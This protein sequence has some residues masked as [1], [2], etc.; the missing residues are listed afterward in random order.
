MKDKRQSRVV[1]YMLI[2]A[3]HQKNF[4][5]LKRQSFKCFKML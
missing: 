5:Q 3:Y 4:I 1:S 2:Q